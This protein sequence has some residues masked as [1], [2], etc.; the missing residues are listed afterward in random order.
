MSSGDLGLLTNKANRILG[1]LRRTCR[2]CKDTE[3]LKV[4]YCTLVRLQVEYESV[5][6]SPYTARNVHKLERIHR[7]E[8]NLFSEKRNFTYDE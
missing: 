2:D 5:V 3:T 6:W 8:Q 7:R 1:L 4:L